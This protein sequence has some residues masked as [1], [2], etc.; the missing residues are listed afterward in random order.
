MG[1]LLADDTMYQEFQSLLREG[2]AAVDDIRETSP[3]TTFT[4]IFFGVF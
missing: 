1:R 4:S 3:I 2:R